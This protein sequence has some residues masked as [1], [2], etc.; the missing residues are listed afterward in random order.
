MVPEYLGKYGPL[1]LANGYELVAIRP[2]TKRPYGDNWQEELISHNEVKRLKKAGLGIKARKTPAVDIDIH[3]ADLVEHMKQFTFETAGVTLERVGLPPKTLLPYR[4][5]VPFRKVNSKVY[6]DEAGNRNKLEVLGL[7][8]QFVVFAI[9][10]DTKKPYKWDEKRAPHDT[11]WSS[12]PEITREQAV[13]IADEFE[14]CAVEKGWKLAPTAN[15]LTTTRRGGKIDLND[16]FATDAAKIDIS[17]DEL[18]STLMRVPGT[19]D[20]D[21]WFQI[22]MALYHQFE[23]EEDGLTLWHQWSA[24]GQ[25]Y[26]SDALDEK[27]STFNIEGK[28][29]APITA[30]VIIKWAAVEEKRLATEAFGEFRARLSSTATLDSMTEVCDEI[31]KLVFSQPVRETLAGIV[32]AKLKEFGNPSPGVGLARS[33][34]RY[35]SKEMTVAPP[36]MKPF[37]YVSSEDRFYSTRAG[38]DGITHKAF[39]SSYDRYMLTPGERLEGKAEPEQHA[40]QVALHRVQIPVVARRLYMPGED[41]LFSLNGVKCVNTYSDDTVPEVPTKLNALERE[42]VARMERHFEHLFP[43]DRDR[44]LL[45]S[46]CAYLIQN[47]GSRINWAPLLQGVDGDGKTTIGEWLAAALGGA[48]ATIIPGTALEEKYTGWAEGAQFVLVEEVRLHGENRY[49]VVNK[50]KPYVGNF[51][52]SIRRMQRDNYKIPNKTCYMLTSNLKDALPAGTNDNRYYPMFSQWQR[53]DAIDAFKAANPNYYDELRAVLNH[54]GVIRH[55]FLTY[56]LH[57]E[58]SPTKRAPES[59]SRRE[60]QQ[61]D[62]DED[63]DAL[64]DMLAEGKLDLCN[65]ILDSGLAASEIVAHGGSMPAGKGLNRFLSKAGFT[66]LGRVKVDGENR[67]LWSRTPSMFLDKTGNPDNDAIRAYL[68]DPDP[69]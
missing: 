63:E 16:V 60:M 12:L 43:I 38:G 28:S 26:D 6:I 42:I 35:E 36:W 2:G 69:L 10:P 22:G 14:R 21:T 34:I 24:Q 44:K 48:N 61:L 59:A 41:L 9:H 5:V 25:K 67:R 49:D 17:T 56:K 27:W 11:P 65:V 46:W 52:V 37:V 7:G 3:D 1:V 20:Y 57:D 29:R 51:E 31:K 39:D 58:F 15:S 4:S 64:E 23:G 53:K 32:K 13:E 55:F 45:L 40:G 8:Q 54:P 66:A 18:A 33:M 68:A 19:D 50:M 62:R 30:K 47:L